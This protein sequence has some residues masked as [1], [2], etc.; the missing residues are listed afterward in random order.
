MIRAV[1]IL[2]VLFATAATAQNRVAVLAFKGPNAAKAQ[3]QLKKSLC[4]AEKCVTP[5]TK[6]REVEVD[7]VILGTVKK[8]KGGLSLELQIYASEDEAP[9]VKKIALKK[10]GTIAP[11]VLASAVKSLKVTIAEQ[12]ASANDDLG[13]GLATSR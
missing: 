9:A 1:V 13:G 10:N 12:V 7:A 6:G 11:K 3:A 4:K 2:A 8:A 5:G